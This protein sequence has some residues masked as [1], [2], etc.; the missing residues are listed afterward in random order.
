MTDCF[1]EHSKDAEKSCLAILAKPL[2]PVNPPFT[3]S[4]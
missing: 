1:V 2:L 4:T 3:L